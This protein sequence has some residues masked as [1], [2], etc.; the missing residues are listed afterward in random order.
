MLVRRKSHFKGKVLWI[1]ESQSVLLAEVQISSL[2]QRF[3]FW[4]NSKDVKITK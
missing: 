4:I 2:D 3:L 1:I